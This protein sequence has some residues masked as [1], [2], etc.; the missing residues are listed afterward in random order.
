[1]PLPKLYLDEDVDPLLAIIL[2]DRGYDV[3]TTEGAG[4]RSASDEEQ[5]E[6]AVGQGRAVITHNVRHFVALAKNY[7]N[8][9][10]AHCGIIVSDQIPLRELLRR[11]LRLLDRYAA[12][13]LHN[14]LIWLQDFK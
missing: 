1:M 7:A 5:L 8:S 11:V 9:G 13:E 3:Q 12:A 2:V 6:W 14:Q 4:M 10:R